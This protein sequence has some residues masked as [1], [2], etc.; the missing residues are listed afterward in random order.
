MA[1]SDRI[2]PGFK[3]NVETAGN[4]KGKGKKKM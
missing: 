3:G 4:D 1:A 2:P